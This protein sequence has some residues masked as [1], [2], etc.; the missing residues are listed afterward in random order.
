VRLFNEVPDLQRMFGQIQGLSGILNMAG[1]SDEA[2]KHNR[3]G[4]PRAV[5]A[6][7]DQLPAYLDSRASILSAMKREE[8][9]ERY[10]RRANELTSEPNPYLAGKLAVLRA[11]LA[12]QRG[13]QA[14]A[15]RALE[16]MEVE[17]LPNAIKTGRSVPYAS[18]CTAQIAA[19][20]GSHAAA[21]GYLATAL[22]ACREEGTLHGERRVRALQAILERA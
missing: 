15:D 22:V 17:V 6:F 20:Q 1:L 10:L 13:D 18:R 11:R 9:A 4:F 21:R 14:T 8:Q 3:Y 5:S 12:I 7:H 19:L 2:W 16:T